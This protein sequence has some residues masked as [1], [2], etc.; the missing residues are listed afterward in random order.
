MQYWI[1]TT[2]QDIVVAIVWCEYRETAVALGCVAAAS[3]GSLPPQH[4]EARPLGTSLLV[5]CRSEDDQKAAE[6]LTN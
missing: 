1:V 2:L 3:T 5:P 4:L 6:N